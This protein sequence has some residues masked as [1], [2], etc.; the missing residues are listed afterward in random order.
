MA[1]Q[2]GTG[3]ADRPAIFVDGG[4]HAR[5]WISPAT[6]MYLTHRLLEDQAD[7]P[8]TEGMT[9]KIDWYIFPVINPDGYE[10]SWN[11]V[12]SRN[13]DRVICTP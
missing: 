7:K 6:I 2:I 4:M 10:Y 11:S 12:R 3:S 13:F 8:S 5:E 9:D 1:K